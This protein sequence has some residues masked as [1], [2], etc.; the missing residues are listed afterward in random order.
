MRETDRSTS[1]VLF[2]FY[3]LLFYLLFVFVAVIPLL[4][5]FFSFGRQ[6]RTGRYFVYILLF[7]RMCAYVRMCSVHDINIK[8]MYRIQ[9]PIYE[10]NTIQTHHDD[11]VFDECLA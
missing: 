7:A 8:K 5:I 6:T 11:D 4:Y 1:S 9:I 2:G 3:F 10:R